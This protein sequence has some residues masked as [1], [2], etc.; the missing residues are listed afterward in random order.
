M[1]T[2]FRT[3]DDK[4][5]VGGQVAPSDLAELQRQGVTMIVNNRPDR[6]EPGQ[7]MSAELEAAAEAVG[8]DYR[9]IPISR[10]LSPAQVEEMV[11]AV[12]ELG[13]G[14]MLA[15]CR[16]GMR[17]TLAWAVASR[18]QGVPRKELEEKARNAGFSL[19]AVS[20]LL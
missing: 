11:S 7:P 13:E 1:T 4:T 20:H 19:A 10:G 16:S 5:L 6:E 18:E 9:H 8:I 15:F 17:S 12:S 2:E 3:L 14:K